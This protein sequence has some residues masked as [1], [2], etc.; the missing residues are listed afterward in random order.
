MVKA[1]EEASVT[2]CTGLLD[3]LEQVLLTSLRNGDF[4]KSGGYQEYMSAVQSINQAYSNTTGLGVKAQ[5]VLL[6]Y[7]QQKMR[8]GEG[9]MA[10]D[11]EITE[12]ERIAVG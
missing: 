5:E 10:A 1:N 9:I 3:T 4:S 8:V 2:K 6:D 12:K 11:K 7:M